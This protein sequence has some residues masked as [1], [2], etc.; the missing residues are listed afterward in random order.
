MNSHMYHA[1]FSELE[2]IAVLNQQRIQA[3]GHKMIAQG[4]LMVNNPLQAASKMQAHARHVA[5][6]PS[7]SPQEAAN[8]L[9]LKS[10][11]TSAK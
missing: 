4:Q 5:S 8:A 7:A 10:A 6:N 1:F 2:K 11:V 9:N 3:Q